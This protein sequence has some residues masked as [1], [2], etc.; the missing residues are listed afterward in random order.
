MSSPRLQPVHA[1]GWPALPVLTFPPKRRGCP[2]L[3]ASF[4]KRVGQHEPQSSGLSL[5]P[6]PYSLVPA[7]PLRQFAYNYLRLAHN[8]NMSWQARIA[9]ED[10]ALNDV[11]LHGES[12]R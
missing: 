8:G 2:V 9:S 11:E 4:A 7:F 1:G 6:I 3:F 12:R 10:R 5:F